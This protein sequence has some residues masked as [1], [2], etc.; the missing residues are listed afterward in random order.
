MAKKPSIKYVCRECGSVHLKWQGKCPDCNAWSTIEEE[1]AAAPSLG[2]RKSSPQLQTSMTKVLSLD[3]NQ[4]LPNIDRTKIGIPE[5]DRV[6]GGGLAPGSFILLSGDPGIGKST[7]LLQ[8]VH[9]YANQG[10][11]VLYASGEESAEQILLR[12]KRLDLMHPNI[13]VANE[14]NAESLIGIINEHRPE[15]LIVDS[16]Q[17]IFTQD[18]PSAPGSVTQVRECAAKLLDVAKSRNMPIWLVGHVT[19][20][21]NIAG[22]RVL[23]H[24]VDCVLYLEGDPHNG[25][26]ILRA[27]KNR[28]GSTGEI[29]VFEMNEDGMRGVSDLGTQFLEH[30]RNQG[31][32]PTGITSTVVMEGTRPLLV[33]IQ[34]LVSRTVFGNPRRV[35]TGV[36]ANRISILLAVLDKRSGINLGMTDVYATAAGG[37]R[38]VEPSVDFAAAVAI[39]SSFLEKPVSAT[40]TFV[41][42]IGLS[43]EVRGCSHLMSRIHEARRMGFE[44]IYVPSIAWN[45]ES[46]KKNR[47]ISGIE[48]IPVR[49]IQNMNQFFN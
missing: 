1:V 29:G 21:G 43:G 23:E 13:L 25:Y 46:Q 12:A 16:I 6:L 49:G 35:V 38:I 18:V 10:K 19:K 33:E 9:A 2:F 8:A 40:S 7:L 34:S 31:P 47:Q 41:G 30:F 27:V 45:Q 3:V 28:F 36:D 37:L 48:V 22:P 17:T 42:E 44:K 14:T 15:M 20:D 24:L 11:K 39:A 5:L 4:E 26:R 32:R